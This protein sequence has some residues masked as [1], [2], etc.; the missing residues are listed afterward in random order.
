MFYFSLLTV[1]IHRVDNND[2][3]TT[4]PKSPEPQGAIAASI[5]KRPQGGLA[6]VLSQIGKKSKLT[7][8]EKSKQDWDG[9]KKEEGIVEELITHNKGK[10]GFVFYYLWIVK[11]NF[12][13]KKKFYF[14]YLEKR[15]FLERTDLRQ[16]ELEK[17]MRAA[18]RSRRN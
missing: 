13:I 8:L 3:N 15:D 12:L 16:F 1:K 7:I 14:R 11:G 17:A 6:N 5:A 9:Y 2:R 18:N 4:K 10:D